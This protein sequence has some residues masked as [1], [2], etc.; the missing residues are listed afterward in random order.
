MTTIVN[1]IE[2]A[3]EEIA[4]QLKDKSSYLRNYNLLESV[5]EY[6]SNC[7]DINDEDFDQNAQIYNH[8]AY[9]LNWEERGD[10][11]FPMSL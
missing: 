7:I 5:S 11:L 1:N 9:D 10:E 2:E 3:V 6:L 8:L 4:N